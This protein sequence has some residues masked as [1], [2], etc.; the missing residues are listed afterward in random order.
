MR[1]TYYCNAFPYFCANSAPQCPGNVPG[2]TLSV[3][4]V[5]GINMC[6]WLVGKKLRVVAAQGLEPRTSGL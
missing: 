2:S 5:P 4:Y 1:K 6:K 3:N